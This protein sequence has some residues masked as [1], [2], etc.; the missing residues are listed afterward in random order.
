MMRGF[1]DMEVFTNELRPRHAWRG[2]KD[3][4]VAALGEGLV[5]ELRDHARCCTR[6]QGRGRIL[7]MGG[8]RL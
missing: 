6:V 3:V 7:R 5:G 8:H 4:H 2:T 1:G